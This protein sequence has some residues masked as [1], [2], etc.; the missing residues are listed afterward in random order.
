MATPVETLLEYLPQPWRVIVQP[1][2]TMGASWGCCWFPTREIWLAPRDLAQM[3]RTLCHEVSHALLPA[4]EG[5]SPRWLAVC[6]ALW[7]RVFPDR[8]GFDHHMTCHL[9]RP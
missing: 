3:Q 5:H 7:D 4:G 2:S 1:E 8:Q 6:G 9:G